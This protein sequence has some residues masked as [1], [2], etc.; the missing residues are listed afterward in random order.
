ML[1]HYEIA[2]VGYAEI[3]HATPEVGTKPWKASSLRGVQ[4]STSLDLG[5]TEGDASEVSSAGGRRRPG[6]G[7]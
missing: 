3:G 5:A 1:H 4:D 6:N 2:S 7:P